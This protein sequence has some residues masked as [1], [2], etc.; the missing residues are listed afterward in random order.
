MVSWR[1]NLILFKNKCVVKNKV[2]GTVKILIKKRGI[3]MKLSQSIDKLYGSE[4]IPYI[5]SL[6]SIKK[7]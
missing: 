7:A 2:V 3:A 1:V 4:S 5:G 6:P